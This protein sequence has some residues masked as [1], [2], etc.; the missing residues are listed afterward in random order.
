MEKSS[1][2]TVLVLVILLPL[3]PAFGAVDSGKQ[4]PVFY[5]YGRIYLPEP[6]IQE[7]TDFIARYLEDEGLKFKKNRE[8]KTLAIRITFYKNSHLGSIEP[9][10]MSRWIQRL[11]GSLP[12]W[13]PRLTGGNMA[14]VQFRSGQRWFSPLDDIHYMVIIE[15]TRKRSRR[16]MAF[17]RYIKDMV[18]PE[19]LTLRGRIAGVKVEFTVPEGGRLLPDSHAAVHFAHSE[20]LDQRKSS[21]GLFLNSHGLKTVRLTPA[22]SNGGKLF[23]PIPPSRV[24]D[25]NGLTVTAG[26]LL[27]IDCTPPFDPALWTSILDNSYIYLSYW[28]APVQPDLARFPFPIFDRLMPLPDHVS[29]LVNKHTSDGVMADCLELAYLLGQS[30]D[31]RRGDVKAV[32]SINNWERGPLVAALPSGHPAVRAWAE[33]YKWNDY[34]PRTNQWKITAKPEPGINPGMIKY[35]SHRSRPVLLISGNDKNDIRQ[36][37]RALLQKAPSKLLNSGT[38]EIKKSLEPDGDTRRF[39]P[40]KSEPRSITFKELGFKNFTLRGGGNVRQNL[41]IP[42]IMG[43]S[44]PEFEAHMELVYSYSAQN[45]TDMASV[46]IQVDGVPFSSLPLDERK[47]VTMGKERVEMPHHLMTGPFQLNFYGHFYPVFIDPC[48]WTPRDGQWMTIFSTSRLSIPRDIYLE[49]PELRWLR[50]WGYPFVDNPDTPVVRIETGETREARSAA[51][52]LAFFFGRKGGH[53][54][55]SFQSGPV[56]DTLDYPGNVNIVRI[57]T[58]FSNQKETVK[59][60]KPQVIQVNLDKMHQNDPDDHHVKTERSMGCF[61]EFPLPGKETVLLVIHSPEPG[62]LEKTVQLL[63]LPASVENFK[64]AAVTADWLNGET[65]PKPVIKHYAPKETDT[66]GGISAGRKAKEF[67]LKNMV[68]IFISVPFVI[69]ALYVILR[70][71]RSL[72]KRRKPKADAAQDHEADDKDDDS[73]SDDETGVPGS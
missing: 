49:M 5:E 18:N 53:Y 17:K 11:N 41:T 21:I 56:Q 51:L 29:F 57:L 58:T 69:F 65:E 20:M 42:L 9:G 19:Q 64:G 66:W 39:F 27:D 36:A 48:K 15:S 32:D 68:W 4:A 10:V 2:I 71:I 14:Y 44:V 50:L 31:W 40:G 25:Y 47:G 46:E 1:L 26:Q 67:F 60:L 38:A 12:A 16:R 45:N 34:D 52:N 8:D 63:S 3:L 59:T 13:F 7:I 61:E 70:L 62:K 30:Y 37:F 73:D 43:T 28:L 22:N 35:F 6:G 23:H 55:L 72:L 24:R 54:P 33:L